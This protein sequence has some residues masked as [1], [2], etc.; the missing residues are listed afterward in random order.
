MGH[1]C[2]DRERLL[3]ATKGL[4]ITSIKHKCPAFA[5]RFKPGDPIVVLTVPWMSSQYPE[6][7]EPPQHWYPGHFVKYCGASGKTPLVFVKAGALPSDSAMPDPF[8][9]AGT[10]FIKAPATRVK[11][12]GWA[13]PVCVDECRN[14]GVITALGQPCNRDEHY[15]PLSKCQA[16]TGAPA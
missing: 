11:P 7:G 15:H 1:P 6:E 10:G 13:P 12:S 5:P 9:P 3:A 2:A 8:E 4:G 14:C 16:Q